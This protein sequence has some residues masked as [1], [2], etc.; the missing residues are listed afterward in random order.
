MFQ[1]CPAG[2]STTVTDTAPFA[3]IVLLTAAVG[4]VAVL[5]SRLT[6]RVKLPSP[7]LVLVGAAIAVKV[8][9]DGRTTD[10][11][12]G[13]PGDAW[14]SFV[15]RDGQLVPIGAKTRLQP[16]DDV[17]VLADPGLHDKL[18]TAFEGPPA[19]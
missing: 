6:E 7:A 11:L 5:S 8:I 19:S 9:P 13:L 4:L 16:G 18:V 15:V 1:P 10:N 2:R 17:L 12:A 3:L 14:V